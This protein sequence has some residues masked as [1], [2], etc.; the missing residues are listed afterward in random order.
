[1]FYMFV[2]MSS[3]WFSEE[4]DNDLESVSDKATM[5]IENGDIVA[6]SDDIEN[7]AHEMGISEKDIII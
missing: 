6:F 2:K 3:G 1:M 5:H 7:F 4:I